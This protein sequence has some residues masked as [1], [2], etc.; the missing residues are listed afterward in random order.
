[1]LATIEECAERG[2]RRPTRAHRYRR[3]HHLP[4]QRFQSQNRL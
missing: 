3:W 2:S 4:C 1:V